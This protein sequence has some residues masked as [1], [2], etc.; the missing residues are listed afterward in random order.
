[1]KESV[2]GY[3]RKKQVLTV[4]TGVLVAYAVSCAVFIACALLL[5]Y[6]EMS[7]AA[8]P[9]I[10]TVTSIVSA[11]IAGFDAAR[12]AQ[13]KGWLWGMVAGLIYA[14][15]LVCIG[16]WTAENFAFDVRT[17]TLFVLCVAG[18][19][20]GGIIGINFNKK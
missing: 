1:M 12:G 11:A 10:V 18:G 19:G 4:A 14:V 3:D 6:T 20:A 7:E 13:G 8:A 16:L 5:T 2:A 17:V 9:V 15:I